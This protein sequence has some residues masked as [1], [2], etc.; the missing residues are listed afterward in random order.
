M[1]PLLWGWE[2]GVL[3]SSSLIPTYK[4]V[5]EKRHTQ[6]GE[7]LK[8]REE[9]SEQRKHM[10]FSLSVLLGSSRLT[11]FTPPTTLE[12]MMSNWEVKDRGL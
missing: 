12:F 1:P 8:K 7:G 6:E 3:F 5:A 9:R 10:G 2:A 11:Q 4:L